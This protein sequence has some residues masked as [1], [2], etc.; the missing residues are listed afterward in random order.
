MV[1]FF[2][3]KAEKE[4]FANGRIVVT[5][6]RK[7]KKEDFPQYNSGD[8]FF[9]HY[10]GKIYLDSREEANEAVIMLLKMLIQYTRA[11]L[12]KMERERKKRFPNI[13]TADDLG[14][15]KDNKEDFLEALAMFI[16]PMEIKSREMERT[17]YG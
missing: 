2:E 7:L 4:V 3:K 1:K 8:M 9:L 15:L 11:E 16:I 12:L 14:L 13:K 5:D 10:D 6:F 17:Y